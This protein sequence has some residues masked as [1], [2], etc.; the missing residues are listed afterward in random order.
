MAPVSSTS[1]STAS[2]ASSKTSLL[3]MKTTRETIYKIRDMNKKFRRACSNL[4]LINN[5]IDE[6][7]VRY[8]RAVAADRR[9]YR[10]ILRLRLCTLEGV[11]NMFYEYA[12]SR[13]DELEK[14]QLKLY[15]TT[16]IAWNDQLA[17]ESGD[18]GEDSDTDDA[19][20]TDDE[21]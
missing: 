14:M 7:E 3:N 11:R 20:E 6:V 19:M 21:Q 18:E 16:G 1:T 17:E 5:L 9:S 13:A 2:P 8:N 10:Y 15:N 4:I 12:Y